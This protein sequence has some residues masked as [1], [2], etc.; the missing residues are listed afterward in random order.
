M[1]LAQRM[2]N[3]HAGTWGT[4]AERPSSA[5][6][7]E[8]MTRLANRGATILLVEDD[9]GLALMLRDRL[10][11]QDH[12][13]WWAE[14]AAD[15]ELTA[16]EICPDLFILDLMLPDAN[17]LVLCANLREKSTAPII[18][19]SATK[20]KDDAVL[21][22]K[23]G[24]IDF[25]AKPFS[26]AEL[27]ARVVSALQHRSG[28]IKAPAVEQARR[29]LG[30][31]VIDPATCRV[32]LGNE[33]VKLTPTEYRLLRQLANRPNT[34]ISRSELAEAVWGSYDL[35]IGRSLDVHLRRLRAKLG[36]GSIGAPLIVAVRG[37]GY[38]LTWDAANDGLAR[39]QL[40][41]A[42]AAWT[43]STT[44]GSPAAT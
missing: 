16:N 11:M 21:C 24:A 5:A 14:T 30:P 27:E 35:G 42:R 41:G 17:G 34:V 44:F 26:I 1:G 39:D 6:G 23:L 40:D 36:H 25:I 4:F 38:Q 37:F 9:T 43:G 7:D 3:A 28:V 20:R 13:V 29:R 22:F 2:R 12:C 10:M 32:T 15:A 19:C 33:I 18:I 31:L 8:S